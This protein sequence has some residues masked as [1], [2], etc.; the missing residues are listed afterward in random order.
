MEK[1]DIK[2]TISQFGRAIGRK[3]QFV[4][5]YIKRGKLV[6]DDGY[7]SLS[8]PTNAEFIRGWK[9]KGNE[10]DIVSINDK[11]KPSP[12]AAPKK[13]VN[14]EKL[15]A[16]IQR[17]KAQTRNEEIKAAKSEQR[18]ISI[19]EAEKLFLYAISGYYENYKKRIPELLDKIFGHLDISEVRKKE[20]ADTLKQ[21][22][23][24]NYIEARETLLS[25]LENIADEYSEVRSKGE[26]K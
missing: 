9:A 12:G 4:Y 6:Q 5:M 24:E 2:L 23:N 17:I 3:R 13:D 26:H 19:N 22:L 25:G 21:R 8:H 14:R 10:F 16:E 7:I 15:I 11:T 1:K 20:L 18:L